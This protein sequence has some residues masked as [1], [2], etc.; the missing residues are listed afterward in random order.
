MRV[1]RLILAV[2]LL[3]CSVT[4]C[5]TDV[6]GTAHPPP[7]LAFVRYIN[8][9]SDTLNLDFRAID[10]VSYSQPFLDVPFRGLGGGNYQGYQA[11]A[12]HVR[13]FDDPN[14]S[15]PTVNVPVG[16]VSTFLVDTT[17]TFTA[18]KYYTIVHIGDARTGSAFPQK[19]WII[20]DALPAQ[21]AGNIGYRVINVAPLTGPVDVHVGTTAALALAAAPAV[22]ALPFQTASPYISQ[23]TA[24]T[25]MVLT[26]PGTATV[27]GAAAGATVQAGTAGTTAADP[28]YGSGVGGS[29]FTAFVFDASAAPAVGSG[30]FA[31][32]GIAFWPDLQPPRTTTDMRVPA[33]RVAKP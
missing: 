23:A 11:G 20:T 18:G 15:D 2:I 6:T 10:Q 21:T 33:T 30:Q 13:V 5:A 19:L 12:R 25:V 7:P 16:A 32:P 17:Y 24:A 29:I 9:V 22:S 4:A 3:A 28:I 26:L 8:A 14:P 1:Q 27:V 31:T